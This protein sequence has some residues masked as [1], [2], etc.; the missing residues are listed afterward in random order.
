[1]TSSNY[2]KLQRGRTGRGLYATRKSRQRVP[3][4]VLAPEVVEMY[5]RGLE[6]GF[7]IATGQAAT[8]EVLP[9]IEAK[10]RALAEEWY[11]DTMPLSAYIEKILHPAYQKILVLGKGAVPFIMGELRDM[12]NDWFWALRILTEAD[13]VKAEETGNMQSMADAWLHWWEVD[14]AGWRQQNGL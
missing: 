2:P 14:G 1:M 4:P 5:K 11:M 9:Q 3:Q 12:P 10:F 13:P 6:H 8:P 7:L